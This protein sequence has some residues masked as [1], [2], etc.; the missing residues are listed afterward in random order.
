[1]SPSG[2]W[3]RSADWVASEG[4]GY[5]QGIV[6]W[7]NDEVQ[8]YHP[9]PIAA[10]LVTTSAGTTTGA[11]VTIRVKSDRDLMLAGMATAT[12]KTSTTCDDYCAAVVKNNDATLLASCKTKCGGDRGIVSA[13]L[14]APNFQ[15]APGMDGGCEKYRVE[16]DFIPGPDGTCQ[17]PAVW[18]LPGANDW[19]TQSGQSVYGGWPYGGEIDIFETA[20]NYRRKFQTIHYGAPGGGHTSSGG[21]SRY[22]GSAA[23]LALEWSTTDI[24]W[25]ENGSLSQRFTSW[26]AGDQNGNPI[27]F[28]APFDRTNPFVPIVNFAMGG[29]LT[30][31]YDYQKCLDYFVGVNG[32]T[33]YFTIDNFRVM[34]SSCAAT[35]K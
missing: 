1:V 20:N 3:F 8:Y 18:M 32:G 11:K 13:K 26:S 15:I 21:S 5:A 24:A 30:G 35:G 2:D 19:A 9:N 6:G 14:I 16:F 10:G 4:F 7:G 33:A 25:F 29:G 23:S 27:P 34:G 28:P 12:G 22:G 31:V 17:W